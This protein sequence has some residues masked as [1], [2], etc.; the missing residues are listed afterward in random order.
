MS[1]TF[2]LRL[3]TSVL[4][5]QKHFVMESKKKKFLLSVFASALVQIV[6]VQLWSLIVPAWLALVRGS[7]LSCIRTC[8]NNMRQE[9]CDPGYACFKL[10]HS[11]WEHCV[12]VTLI[13]L[14]L[15]PNHLSSAIIMSILWCLLKQIVRLNTCKN[16]SWFIEIAGLEVWFMFVKETNSWSNDECVLDKSLNM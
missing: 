1:C 3:V 8:D 10:S 11:L 13:T 2:S 5:C 14:I 15:L 12:M 16:A 9:E 4:F 7:V 6:G